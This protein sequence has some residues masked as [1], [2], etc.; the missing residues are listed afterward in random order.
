MAR[1]PAYR[2]VYEDLKKKI[3]NEEYKKGELLPNESQLDEIYN[4][5]RTT[6]R[7]AIQMLVEDG[8]IK[9]KQ[10][11]G[12]IVTTNKTVQ[13]LN[14]FNSLSETLKRRGYTVEV[15]GV[16]VREV[17]AD[18]FLA[19]QFDVA[20]GFP[21]IC[22]YRTHLADGVPVAIARN[23]IL[24]ELVPGIK[25]R[26][27]EIVSLYSFLKNNYGITYDAALDT[28]S[29]CNSDYEEAKLLGVETGVA[30]LTVNRKCYI[31]ERVSELALVKILASRHEFQ[32]YTNGEE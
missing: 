5:S 23:Y 8:Y 10:G 2:I 31:N 25:S 32:V 12:T 7:K 26:A 27:S 28:I 1:F 14:C 20:K 6:V 9:V 17:Y 18:E 11:F 13:N 15:E 3:T 19:K 29:A 16:E 21:L 4:V 22:I 24:K 30:L